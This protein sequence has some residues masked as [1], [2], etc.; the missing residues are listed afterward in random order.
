[1][2]CSIDLEV[3][4]KDRKI[5]GIVLCLAI[6]LQLITVLGVKM[7][8]AHLAESQIKK[9]FKMKLIIISILVLAFN[10][11][12]YAEGQKKETYI[13]SAE[14]INELKVD[15][16]SSL[17]KN[18]FKSNGLK[19]RSIDNILYLINGKCT[20]MTSQEKGNN[21]LA[22]TSVEV[23]GNGNALVINAIL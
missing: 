19:V 18:H 6:L 3:A 15:S 16:V 7:I 14:T 11:S 4:E 13:Y 10:F 9:E 2:G 12:V 23:I 17:I 20:K 5:V 21:L 22:A 8:S 1:L